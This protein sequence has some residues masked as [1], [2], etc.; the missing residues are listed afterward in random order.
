MVEKLTICIMR[1]MKNAKL[2]TRSDRIDLETDEHGRA[3]NLKMCNKG[4]LLKNQLRVRF[5]NIF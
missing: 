1:Y 3:K 5:M 2:L 4:D